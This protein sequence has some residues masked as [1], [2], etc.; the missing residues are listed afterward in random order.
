MHNVFNGNR[1]VYISTIGFTCFSALISGLETAGVPFGALSD[2]MNIHMFLSRPS[3]LADHLPAL[4][5]F[6]AG[7]IA[8]AILKKPETVPDEV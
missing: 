6:I 3:A 1:I 8:A 4:T 2:V 7:L 5:G